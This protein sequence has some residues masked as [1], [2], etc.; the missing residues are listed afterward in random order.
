DVYFVKTRNT[1]SGKVEAF[2]VTPGS[3]YTSGL[4]TTTRF[5]PAD[6]SN[7]WFGMLPNGA[8]YS[9]TTTK[10]SSGRVVASTVTPGSGYP[11]GLATTTRFSPADASNGWFGML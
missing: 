1:S 10:D 2:T 4:A 5:S 9:G 6:A 7:G 8:A 11:S 3:G